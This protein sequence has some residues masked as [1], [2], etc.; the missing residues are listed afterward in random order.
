M[1]SAELHPA[2]VVGSSAGEEP[3]EP[4]SGMRRIMRISTLDGLFAVQYATLTAGP[5]L[6]AFLVAIGAGAFEVGLAAALPL[7]GGLV[8]PVGAEIV[9]RRGGHRKGVTIVAALVDALLWSLSILAV[10]WLPPWQALPVVLLVMGVQQAA[11]AVVAASWTS[12]ISDLIPPSLRGRFFGTRNFVTNA[13]GAIT[14]AAAGFAV[15]GADD[16]IPVYLVLI[17]AGA[18]FRLV[19]IRFLTGQPEPIPARSIPGG[20][21]RQLR[22]P[23]AQSGF[24]RYVLFSAAWGFSVHFVAPFFAVYMLMQIGISV[25][26]VM[27]FSALGIVSNLVGQRVWGPLADRHGDLQVMRQAGFWVAIQPFWWLLTDASGPGYFLMPVLSIIGGFVWGGFMLATGN[28]MMRLAPETGKTSFF[29]V[30]GALGGAFGAAGPIVGGAVAGLLASSW[31]GQASGPFE[32]LK[33]L[34]LVAGLLRLSSWLLLNVVP[35]PVPGPR[36][37]AVLVIRDT[38]RSMNPVQG[39]GPLLQLFMAG[40]REPDGPPGAA[41]PRG[42]DGA[43]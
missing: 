18:A 9:R 10:A 19:S 24:R 27:T 43:S 40:R 25:A 15:R 23:L 41:D 6:T 1:V 36:L 34:F 22:E 31:I 7:L 28:L 11:T 35:E 4:D 16:P 38:M 30:Q 2:S 3:F 17:A 39:F 29:A 12:W 33:A 8:Q 20:A 42:T 5:F 37:R 14:A 21:L 26:S 13:F 32:G